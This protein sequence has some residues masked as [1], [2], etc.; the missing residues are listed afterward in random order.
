[1]KNVNNITSG[2]VY[3]IK[4]KYSFRDNALR[5]VSNMMYDK[6][7]SNYTKDI[8]IQK[9]KSLILNLFKKEQAFKYNMKIRN[10]MSIYYFYQS[11]YTKDDKTE[12]VYLVCRWS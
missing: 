3:I 7:Y 9:D 6:N 10:C 8:S 1:M 11:F 12:D 2:F 5:L 4:S